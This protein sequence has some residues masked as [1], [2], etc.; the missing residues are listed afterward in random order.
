[1]TQLEEQIHALDHT[2]REQRQGVAWLE[3]AEQARG[4]WLRNNEIRLGL[5]KLPDFEQFPEDA[6]TRFNHFAKDKDQL[7]GEWDKQQ[8]V[9]QQLQNEIEQ[10]IPNPALLEN[11]TE[12]E[13]LYDQ[14]PAYRVNLTT[15]NE[16]TMEIEQQ[17]LQ[18]DRLLRQISAQ[19]NENIL[20]EYAVTVLH[21]EQVRQ[22]ADKLDLLQRNRD[23]SKVDLN[24]L[25]LQVEEA[26]EKANKLEVKLQQKQRQI[27]DDLTL[28]AQQEMD[29]LTSIVS[30]LRKQQQQKQQLRLEL[31]KLEQQEL[32]HDGQAVETD[33]AKNTYALKILRWFSLI[34]NGML[35]LYLVLKT[36]QIAALISFFVLTAVSLS[37][38][39]YSPKPAN[40]NRSQRLFPDVNRE[41]NTNPNEK[42][43]L[44]QQFNA[45]EKSLSQR[46]HQ[47]NGLAHTAAAGSPNLKTSVLPSAH[48]LSDQQVEGSFEILQQAAIVWREGKQ[49]LAMDEQRWQEAAD[50]YDKLHKLIKLEEVKLEALDKELKESVDA[51]QTWLIQNQLAAQLSP[52]GALE[53]F[54]LIETGQQQLQIKHRNEAKRENL[55]RSIAEFEQQTQSRLGSS[56]IDDIPASLKKWKEAAQ[57]TQQ[58]LQ[59]KHHLEHQLTLSKSELL[60]LEESMDRVNQRIRDLWL[61]AGAADEQQFRLHVR[62]QGERVAWVDELQQ[63]EAALDVFIGAKRRSQLEDLL[64]EL[65]P[66]ELKQKINEDTQ[67]LKENEQSADHLKENRGKLRNEL[68]KLEQGAEH[69]ERLQ[70]IQEQ[71]AVLTEQAGQWA[72]AA[73]CSALFRKARELY[74]RE[75]QPGVLLLATEYFHEITAGEYVRVLVPL[76][77]KRIVVEHASGR[78][79]D[80]SL[81]SR[82]TAEQLYLAMRFALA[83]EYARKASL[84]L[85]LDDILVNFDKERMQQ[86]IS[87]LARISQKHQIIFFTCHL[88]MAEAFSQ[89]IPDHQQIELV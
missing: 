50:A 29:A 16:V 52:T 32:T 18:L 85:I 65:T 73:F 74:E 37:L 13:G 6:M 68:E 84:P 69:S 1:L 2:V 87:L 25:S 8:H 57:R 46:L 67:A 77:E 72:T 4:H 88:H 41:V 55:L 36:Q 60:L 42:D 78:L 75:R 56:T 47:L 3:A 81:L 34:V 38:W 24:R 27:Y 48:P 79:M 5:A 12:L 26:R 17:Q 66:Q 71:S 10:I 62:Q 59:Q 51:W 28:E 86:T 39:F 54:Q 33:M 35:P 45:L 49:E 61:E 23:Q 7:L 11:Q 58:D 20:V 53:I 70:H 63:L 19:W 76:G 89:Q 40:A 9:L 22:W 14:L 15:A 43:Q 64:L 30:Q 80:S 31:L 21:R 83:E 44:K 82:G